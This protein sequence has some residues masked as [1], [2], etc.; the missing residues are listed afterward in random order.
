MPVN[1]LGPSANAASAT[2]LGTSSPAS[3]RSRS[4]PRMPRPPSAPGSGAR[5]V[6]RSASIETRAPKRGRI[7]ASWAPTW[8]VSAGQPVMVTCPPATSAATRNGAAFERS[9][10]MSTSTAR[11]GPGSTFQRPG[12]GLATSMPRAAR[13][14][15]VIS[16]C[17]R[18]GRRSPT[19]RRS[20]PRSNRGAESS[21][22]DTNWLD[23]DASISSGPPRD[24]TR[25]VDGEREGAAAVVVE[26]DAERLQA[27]DRAA[28]RP[29][30]GALV[31]VEGRRSERERRDRREEAHHGA[32]ESAVDR[33]GAEELVGGD[34][35]EV[36]AEPAGCRH[37]LES[38][39]ERA[40]PL[41]HELA[42]ARPERRAQRR[43]AVGEGREHELAIGE[44]LR[45][46][47]RHD[48]I[49]A[50][51]W[52]RAPATRRRARSASPRRTDRTRERNTSI[53]ASVINSSVSER[54]RRWCACQSWCSN[55]QW[56]HRP[57]I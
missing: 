35:A 45:A 27:L 32:G 50:V 25:A 23:A 56:S 7:S 36:V 31:A 29:T 20:R 33:G 40:Q 18:L 1:V 14:A 38:R 57:T 9:G 22:P 47:E 34:D 26:V 37:P 30:A 5:T 46:G 10:S 8:V 43:R 16:M 19:W 15:I 28:H 3:E 13:V 52:R 49:R 39:A 17:G 41:D 42:V 44:R 54:G 4:T 55:A 2:R 51:P 6:S 53:S 24:P 11:I 48:A 21:R 12:S